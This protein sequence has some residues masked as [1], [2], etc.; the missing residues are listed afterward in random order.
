MV[1]VETEITKQAKKK[2]NQQQATFR[3]LPFTQACYQY[4]IPLLFGNM[5]QWSVEENNDT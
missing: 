5:A 3:K 1:Q 4:V 2:K